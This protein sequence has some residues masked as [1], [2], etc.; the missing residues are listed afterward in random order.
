MKHHLV[1]KYVSEFLIPFVLLFALY[2]Q[3]HGDYGPGGG[4]QAGVIFGAGFILYGLIW[5][6]DAKLRAL[7][8]SVA[9]TMAAIGVLLYTLVGVFGILKGGE[10]LNYSVLSSDPVAG[11]HLGILLIELG[12]GITVASVMISLFICFSDYKNSDKSD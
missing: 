11:Q 6:K 12:V 10:F 2:V 4:F 9:Y 7:P 8:A 5:G 1:L 3:A